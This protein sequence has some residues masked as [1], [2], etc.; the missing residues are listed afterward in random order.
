MP[1][2]IPANHSDDEFV[3]HWAKTVVWYQIFPERFRNGDPGNEPTAADIAG[4]DP[5]DPP[6]Q[7][8]VHPW[9]SDW[10]RLQPWEQANNEP[11]MWKHLLRRR[12]GGDLQG[13]IDQLDYLQDLGITALYL[14]P[15]FD[16]PSSHK[17]DGSSYHHIDPNFGP[18]PAGDRALMAT[19]NPLDP[20]TWVWTSAD[21]LAL[22]LIRQV[23]QRGMRIIFDGV[24]NHMGV[25]SFAFRDLRQ[26]QQRSPYR[27][28]FNVRSFDDPEQ[29]T[30]FD[31]DG[32]WGIKSLPNFRQDQNGLVT[33]PRDYVFAAT[34]R[35]LN[36]KGMGTAHGLDGWR[37]DVA[38]EVAHPF[39]KDWR[40]HVRS[41]NPEAYI[42]AELVVPPEKV[43]PYL[44]G[45]EF[46]AEM[47]YNFAFTVAEFMINTGA[48]K[49]S[50]SEFDRQLRYLR[51]LYPAGV[52]YA[53]QNLYD[54]HD[55][56]RV[57]SQIV[58]RGLGNYRDWLHYHRISKAIDNPAYSPRKPGVGERQVQKLLVL[59]QM[60]YVG[61]PMVYYG[62]EVGMWG[63]NDPCC[64]KPMLWPDI[65]YEP[66][67]HN[68]DGSARAPE[69]TDSVVIDENLKNHY[70][71][72]IGI[73]N[74]HPALQLG[75]FTTLLV[76]DDRDLYGFARHYRGE[77]IW[78]VLNNA[79]AEHHV[80]LPMGSVKGFVVLYG[81]S[82]FSVSNGWLG[83]ALPAIGGVVLKAT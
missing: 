46:D 49:A 63:A 39:W 54:S 78:V 18:D 53:M 20:A 34:E 52:A 56:N 50:A 14:N 23:H 3:P 47:N 57:S 29:G 69:Q 48:M 74:R 31:Y 64:R 30:S 51:E 79:A 9:G 82:D 13:I 75:D 68:P 61:A 76:D 32:W 62:D 26:N 28:W 55:A 71:R 25:K 66:E 44:Q 6:K 38:Y 4:A 45:D 59:L 10:Y 35:W 60:T 43:Q 17:Y 83:L 65:E 37:L 58:N 41:I 7:W 36:P 5:T 70:R 1:A 80:S 15:V 27:D 11:E 42:T 33:G 81:P 12:Y 24:F 77:T 40:R 22:E 19:E 8:R 67:R 2:A 16:S 72:L 73:R 21:E